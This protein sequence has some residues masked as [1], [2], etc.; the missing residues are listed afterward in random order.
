MDT[1]RIFTNSPPLN[2]G[3][4][5]AP[6]FQPAIYN[7]HNESG[8]SYEVFFISSHTEGITAQRNVTSGEP[9]PAGRYPHRFHRDENMKIPLSSCDLVI[10]LEK[11]LRNIVLINNLH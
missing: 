1:M 9:T 11:R 3:F 10:V 8:C 2:N 7:V 4:I 6:F 5:H